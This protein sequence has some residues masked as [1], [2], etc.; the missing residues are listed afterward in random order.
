MATYWKFKLKGSTHFHLSKEPEEGIGPARFTLCGR[1]TE[2][3]RPPTPRTIT[4]AEG[5]ECLECVEQTVAG[6][7]A[8]ILIEEKHFGRREKNE[9]LTYLRRAKRKL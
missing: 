6:A 8:E 7:E 4:E 3:K 1:P 5:D 9:A 2:P